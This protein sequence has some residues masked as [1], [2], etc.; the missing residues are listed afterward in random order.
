[1]L[2]MARQQLDQIICHCRGERP[3]EA[4]GLIAGQRIDRKKI[5]TKIFPC[6]NVLS[7]TTRY[8]IEPHELLRAVEDIESARNDLIAIYH[9]HPESDARP[10]QIDA[11]HAFYPTCSYLIIS[12]RGGETQIRSWTLRDKE[13]EEELIQ[14]TD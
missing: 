5:A 4:C 12:L 6:N 13:F 10:S 7:S 2:I 11:E 9:S 8:E 14:L 1:M 3:E